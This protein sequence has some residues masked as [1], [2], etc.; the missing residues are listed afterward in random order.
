MRFNIF[1]LRIRVHASKEEVDAEIGHH[2]REERHEHIDM[3]D[4]GA[5]QRGD[6]ETMDG[7]G[8]DHE[9]D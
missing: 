3:V 8:I 6:G 9:S 4:H 2:Y 7:D 5:L 1:Y